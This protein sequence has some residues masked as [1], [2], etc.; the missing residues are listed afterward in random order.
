MKRGKYLFI[1]IGLFCVIT[2][3]YASLSAALTINGTLQIDNNSWG[4]IFEKTEDET[5]SGKGSIV[6]PAT[7]N[8]DKDEVSFSVNLSKPGDEYSVKI[9]RKNIGTIDA[10]LDSYSVIGLE[11]HENYLEFSLVNPNA[12]TTGD[13]V[14]SYGNVMV[15]RTLDANES[16]YLI[17]TLR[18]KTDIQP[19]DLLEEP[20][21]L[22]VV[23]KMNYIQN[24]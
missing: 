24:V 13:D 18:F 5:F 8:T 12:A 2:L 15:D 3:G 7:I 6:N 16:D 20:A 23:V 22:N 9:Y 10:L 17:L 4:V 21:T 19:V 1:I 14:D 11:G